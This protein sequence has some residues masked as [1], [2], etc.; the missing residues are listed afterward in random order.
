MYAEDLVGAFRK[1]DEKKRLVEMQNEKLID[2]IGEEYR[3][4][5]ENIL[6]S[7][8]LAEEEALLIVESPL[9]EQQPLDHKEHPFLAVFV[10]QVSFG[11]D[12][13]EGDIYAKIEEGKWLKIPFN[14]S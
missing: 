9:G 2:S 8:S 14:Y 1:C 12:C 4:A 3:E 11:D 10:H 5:I 7:W 6:D 13:N